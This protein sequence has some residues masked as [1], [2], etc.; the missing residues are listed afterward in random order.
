MV[1]RKD[2]KGRVW[3]PN[4]RISVDQ[5]LQVCTV[6][7]ARASY[8]EE[9]KGSITAGKL[10]D[11]VVLAEDPHEVDPDRIK[12]IEIVRTVVGGRTM[13]PGEPV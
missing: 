11:F 5:A 2:Y 10:A 6:N 13:F 8:E 3:G 4:Q 12:E 9:I 1:T 7:A